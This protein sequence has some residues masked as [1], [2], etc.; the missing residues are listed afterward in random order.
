[1]EALEK[2]FAQDFV[3]TDFVQVTETSL[4]SLDFIFGKLNRIE[5]RKLFKDK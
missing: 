5:G 4:M 3:V 1:M 2:L